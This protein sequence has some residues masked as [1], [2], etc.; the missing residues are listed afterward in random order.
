MRP[1]TSEERKR[2]IDSHPEAAPG[3]IESDLGEYE[4]LVARM[5][6]RDPDAPK[7]AAAP[8]FEESLK[9]DPE[10]LRLAQLH[11]KLFGH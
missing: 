11:A 3:E 6:Q 9:A 7:P 5:F 1:L 8:G 4:R 2:V 10:Q